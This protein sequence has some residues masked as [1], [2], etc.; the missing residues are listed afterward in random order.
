MALVQLSQIGQHLQGVLWSAFVVGRCSQLQEDRDIAYT[1]Q[2]CLTISM[3]ANDRRVR[4][5]L[6]GEAAVE[7]K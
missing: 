6:S 7:Y 5:L 2:L 4:R 1:E 3:H